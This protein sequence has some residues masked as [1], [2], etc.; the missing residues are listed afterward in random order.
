MNLAFIGLGDLGMPMARRLL[1]VGAQVTA[2][3]RS[4]EKLQAL[5]A[6]GATTAASPA[7]LMARTDIVG[8]CL[9]SH[10]AVEEVAWGPR[11]LFSS[12]APRARFIADFSTGSPEAAVSFARRAAE[13][14]VTWVDTP[15]S[16]GAAA[17]AAGKLI[18]FAGGDVDAIAALQPLL[19]PL[20]VRVS[21]MGSVGMGQVMKLCNNAISGC[22]LLLIAETIALARKADI[23]VMHFAEALKGGVADSPHLQ[24]FGPRMAEH[25]FEPRLGAIALIE[26]DVNLASELA[27]ARG[28]HTP[29]LS[30]VRELYAG[31][32]EKPS[33]DVTA[34]VSRLIGLFESIAQDGRS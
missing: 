4:A 20:A 16:G 30:L 33:I 5:A 11:G 32:R 17:A 15:F 34:D 1:S 28:A 22:V 18:V 6:E 23:D 8:L 24:I 26:R 31:A 10:Q 3:N 12:T 19:S 7:E 27:A 21:R 13:R 2:W 14:Q 9:N 29:I 25:R